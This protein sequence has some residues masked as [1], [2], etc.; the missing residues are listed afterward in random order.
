MRAT[1]PRV[2]LATLVRLGPASLSLTTPETRAMNVH[3][4][5]GPGPWWNRTAGRPSTR[6]AQTFGLFMATA[7]LVLAP[8]GRKV[9][10]AT[11]ERVEGKLTIALSAAPERPR[12]GDRVRYTVRLVDAS[13]RPTERAKVRLTA[14]M[15]DGMVIR[16]DLV[17]GPEPGTYTGTLLFTMAGRWQVELSIR[18]SAGSVRTFFEEVVGQR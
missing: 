12:E 18:D 13:G 3:G 5:H 8:V 16:G 1:R 9:V 6:G 2:L 11:F 15:A 4:S 17:P 14:A 10:P 7:L